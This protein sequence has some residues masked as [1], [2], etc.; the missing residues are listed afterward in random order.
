MSL[1]LPSRVKGGSRG[2]PGG[3]AVKFPCSASA[4][5]DAPVRIPGVDMVPLGEA[6]LW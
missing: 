6:M 5:R 1:P 3:A 2:Q 4:A